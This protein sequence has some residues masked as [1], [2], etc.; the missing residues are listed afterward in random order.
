MSIKGRCH[1]CGNYGTLSYE[2]I[3]PRKAFNEKPVIRVLLNEALTLGPGVQAKGKIQQRG[4]GDFTLCPKCNNATGAW[5]GKD[6][7]DWCYQGIEILDKAKGNP[8]LIYLYKLKPLNILKQIISMF[9]SINGPGIGD[10]HPELIK[11]VLNKKEKNL[12]P[13][14]R[15][16]CYFNIE[17][18]FRSAEISAMIDANTQE[19]TL[20]S[21]INFPPYGYVM[22]IDAKPPDKR[23]AEITHFSKYS[24]NELST[25]YI[26]LPVLPTHLFYSGDYRSKEEIIDGIKQTD[27]KE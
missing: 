17:G 6:L 20:L 25:H 11:F 8:T 16:F 22:T 1:L 13:S 21:E 27:L 3:P 2:H 23:L 14:F 9:F 7:I 24:Y 5:Y 19:I 18:I 12:N 15:F 10:S 4:A 26:K